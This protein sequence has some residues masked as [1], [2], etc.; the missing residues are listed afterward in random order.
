M[1]NEANLKGAP[2]YD[3]NG[4]IGRVVDVAQDTDAG[5]QGGLWVEIDGESQPV[6]IPMSEFTEASPERVTLSFAREQLP[7]AG[8]TI[9]V[10]LHEEVLDATTRPVERGKVLIHKTVE[11]EPFERLV[12]VGR[13]DVTVERVPVDRIVAQAPAPRWEGDTLIV[14]LVEEVLV[15][16]KRLRVREELRVTRRR[17]EE[18]QKV[19]DTL[20]REVAHIETTGDTGIERAP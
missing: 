4:Q 18:Q 2:V 20:R 6:L 10:P 17:T 7:G 3:A 1:W 5:G 8:Q 16:E 11:T 15:V 12:T 13:E 19:G 9:R 14:P